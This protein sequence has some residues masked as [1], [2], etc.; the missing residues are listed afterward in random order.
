MAR[1]RKKSKKKSKTQE[2]EPS[3]THEEQ[4]QVVEE[5]V[6]VENAF[7]QTDDTKK[8]KRK[9]PSSDGEQEKKQKKEQ[10]KEEETETSTALTASDDDKKISKNMPYL[11]NACMLVSVIVWACRNSGSHSL[12]CTP[13]RRNE[14]HFFT[15]AH[16]LLILSFCLFLG[17]ADADIHD[18]DGLIDYYSMFTFPR[19]R[20]QIRGPLSQYNE[21]N[22]RD[23]IHH[24]DGSPSSLHSGS[25]GK[26]AAWQDTKARHMCSLIFV[27]ARMLV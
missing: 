27:S 10:E 26:A 25:P 14:S 17:H 16:T 2:E 6:D 8:R 15:H 3:T 21:G 4:K 5:Q 9:E 11:F 19:L 20:F 18:T 23:E 12:I 22:R 24:Y 13:S 1:N 7:V